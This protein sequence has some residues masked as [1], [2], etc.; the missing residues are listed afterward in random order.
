MPVTVE[1][2]R[3]TGD[4]GDATS[5]AVRKD[6]GRLRSLDWIERL[7]AFNTVSRE[8]NLGLIETIRDHLAHHGVASTLTYDSGRNKA[9][10]FAT[11]A[12]ADGA[13]QGGV[14]LSGHTDVVPVDGQQWDTDPFRPVVRD[15]KLFGRG[16]CDM[17]SYIGVALTALPELL[18][19]KLDKPVHF[20][21]SY[22]EEIGC[23][24][25]PSMIA[26]LQA[27]GVR[28]D[29]CIV[30]EPTSMRP[31]VAH[32]SISS[33]RCCVNGHAAHSS[34]T[35]KGVNAI[36]YAARLI[37]HIRD[38]A[39]GLKREGPFDEDFDV[40]FST[41]SVGTIQ[42]GIAVNTVPANC[43]FVFEYR[44]LPSVDADRLIERIQA[45]A[46][47]TLVPEMRKVA[48]HA[49]IEFTRRSLSPALE[50]SE[51]DAITQL[52]RALTANRETHKVAYGTEAGLFQRAGIPSVICG[53]GD[54]E[55]AHK[56][57]E[58]VLLDQ[59]AQCEAFIG[60]L[61]RSMT[62]A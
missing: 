48:P 50:A 6:P 37:C 33:F 11:F 62:L 45:Y 40:P 24:G 13:T 61:I 22:D 57:N 36:E 59:I 43:E 32:K 14:V 38:I 31:I 4:A 28:P 7:I 60:K 15:G 35:P 30:G 41:A 18:T 8:S 49:S 55:Q 46:H 2:A 19:T 17:K 1:T 34:L 12:A 3:V 42:G 56:A 10:L 52:V 47:D 58:F 39:D 51:Q 27:R 21:F 53:P 23:V 16:S 29:G 54:I 44:T 5:A 20:A 9:N 26:E 25:A